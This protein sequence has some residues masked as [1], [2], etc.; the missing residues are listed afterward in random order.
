MKT[1]YIHL[2][3]GIALALSAYVGM[4]SYNAQAAKMSLVIVLMAYYWVSEAMPLPVTSLLPI[5]LF[6]LF[7][8]TDLATV[9]AYY[10]KP[11]IYLFLGGFMLALA[12]E[13]TNLHE[14]IA[15]FILKKTG[16][17]PAQLILGFMTASAFLSMWISNTAAVMVMLPIGISVLQEAQTVSLSDKQLTNLSVGLMLGIAY[18]ANVGGMATLIGTAPNMVFQEIYE[19]NFHQAFGFSDWLRHAFPLT[20]IM[21]AVIWLI[22]SKIM[23][24]QSGKQIIE[25]AEIEQK[26]Q[27]LGKISPDEKRT[28]YIFLLAVVL[29]LTGNNL[30]ITD[31]FTLKG[32]R[33]IFG[34]TELKDASV[35]IFCALLLFIIPSH[36][37]N[38]K[39]PV[40]EWNDTQKIPW[41]ILL[42]FGG[43]F[44]IAGGFSHSG[45]SGLIAQLFTGIQSLSTFTIVFIISL[46]ITF[47]TEITSNT[48]ITTLT[49]PILAGIAALSNFDPL[50]LMFPATISASCAF[51]MPTATPPQAIVYSSGYIPIRTMN[52]TGLV[53]NLIAALIITVYSYLT[54]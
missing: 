5:V 19:E 24:K 27:A 12:L 2:L 50:L 4:Q 13:K 48:A 14:R 53:V 45:L 46:V 51:M 34:L 47:V 18:A 40:L 37:S 16:G 42:L 25:Q 35:A 9:T 8:I 44:A 26:Y 38:H 22:L 29:W 21:F 49:M 32:W 41:G 33:E 20:V 15:L 23:Y 1:K 10:G 17:K 11:T 7:E 36:K 39:K 31:N 3:I 52:K 6:P 28:A 30:Q 43:G 54:L